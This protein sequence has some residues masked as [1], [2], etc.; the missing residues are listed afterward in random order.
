[1]LPRSMRIRTRD[2]AVAFEEGRTL[3]HPLLHLRVYRRRR[4]GLARAAFIVPKRFGKAARRNRLRRRVRERY[5]L[6]C[7]TESWGNRLPDSD[8]LFFIQAR[9][10]A[11]TPAQLDEALRQLLQRALRK[12]HEEKQFSQRVSE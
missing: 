2:F 3:R 9:S 11:A 4:N 5:R 1:M 10:E 7:L 8:L 12:S 6:L